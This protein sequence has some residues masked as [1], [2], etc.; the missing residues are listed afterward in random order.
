MPI[1]P[2][3]LQTN[4]L[5]FF[6]FDREKHSLIKPHGILENSFCLCRWRVRIYNALPSPIRCILILTQDTGM[7][8]ILLPQ[9]QHQLGSDFVSQIKGVGI[10]PH[11]G[12]L[13]E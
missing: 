9:L 1:K 4:S 3:R 8:Y 13:N 2:T 10:E 7:F 5:L 11:I 6:I 12:T